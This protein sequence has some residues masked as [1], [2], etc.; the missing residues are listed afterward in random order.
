MRLNSSE[1]IAKSPDSNAERLSLLA[2]TS[3]AI[4]RL[5]ARH[6]NASPSLLEKLSHS[7]DKTTR[8]HVAIHPNA[9]K[10]VL[11]ELLANKLFAYYY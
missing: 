6:P 9:P 4:D 5:L 1:E 2:G 3:K 7:R 8:K 11:L 10:S